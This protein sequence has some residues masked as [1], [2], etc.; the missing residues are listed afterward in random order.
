MCPDFGRI[1]PLYRSLKGW[2][3]GNLSLA[4]TILGNEVG[5]GERGFNFCGLVWFDG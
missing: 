3:C 5:N 1:E 2:V 4:W